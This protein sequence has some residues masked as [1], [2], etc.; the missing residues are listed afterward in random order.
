MSTMRRL[1]GT[2]PSNTSSAPTQGAGTRLL[3]VEQLAVDEHQEHDDPRVRRED[4]PVPRRRPLGD[5]GQ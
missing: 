4:G 3:P 1:L 5:R 2:G